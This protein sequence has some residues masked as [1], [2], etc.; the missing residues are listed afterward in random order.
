MPA[1]PAELHARGVVE[2]AGVAGHGPSSFATCFLSSPRNGTF[3]QYHLGNQLVT[4][5]TL[6][7]GAA[8]EVKQR[9]VVHMKPQVHAR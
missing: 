5:A 6:L 9:A 8:T 2:A 4:V 7:F 3:I 1:A